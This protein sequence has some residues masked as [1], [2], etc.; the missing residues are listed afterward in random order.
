[1][2]PALERDTFD[3]D[4]SQEVLFQAGGPVLFM[5]YTFRRPFTARRIGIC[6]DGSRLAS[7][8]VCDAMPLLQR[9]DAI[10][11]ITVSNRDAM[12]AEASTERLVQYLARLGLPAT[13]V[14]FPASPSEV[15]PAIL[16][17]A[18]DESLDLLVM[19]GYGH[20][21]LQERILG[22]VTRAMLRSMTVPT[23]MSH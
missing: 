22:G 5:P 21:R 2:R 16:S 15:Q 4:I 3:N 9:A 20:S 8:A 19:G 7:R 1:M 12:S 10:T 13:V 17:V 11:I 6:W 14:N 23:P 18:A